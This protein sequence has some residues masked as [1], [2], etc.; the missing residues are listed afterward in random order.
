M[1]E[2]EDRI[3]TLE[4]QLSQMTS[5]AQ[6]AE[7]REQ[8]LIHDVRAANTRESELRERIHVLTQKISTMVPRRVRKKR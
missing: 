3:H 4:I 2:R 5:R 8:G 7:E 1:H 6:G